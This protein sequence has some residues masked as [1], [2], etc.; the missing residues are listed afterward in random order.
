M[1]KQLEK[2]KQNKP[3]KIVYNANKEKMGMDNKFEKKLNKLEESLNKQQ[4]ERKKAED[5]DAIIIKTE[6]QPSHRSHQIENNYKRSMNNMEELRDVTE[7]KKNRS[8][9]GKEN[10]DGLLQLAK[11]PVL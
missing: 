1:Q 6:I 5:M 10:K 7:R 9:G 2:E 3:D 11:Q 8:I 4:E